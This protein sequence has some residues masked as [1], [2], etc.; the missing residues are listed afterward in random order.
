MRIFAIAIFHCLQFCTH[1]RTGFVRKRGTIFFIPQCKKNV[2]LRHGESERNYAVVKIMGIGSLYCKIQQNIKT[3][4]FCCQRNRIKSGRFNSYV[5]LGHFYI[6]IEF[7][8]ISI[9][10]FNDEC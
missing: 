9:G 5:K 7:S 3:V 10:I 6:D 4:R 8:D 1:F 2:I